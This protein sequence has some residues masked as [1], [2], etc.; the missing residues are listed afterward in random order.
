METSEQTQ[1]NSTNKSIKYVVLGVVVLILIIGIVAYLL[2]APKAASPSGMVSSDCSS[3]LKRE[4]VDITYTKDNKFSPGCVEV[5]AGTKLVYLNQSQSMLQVG[6]DPHP[7]HD[8]NKEL[9]NGEFV[10]EV[11][12][13]GTASSVVHETGTFG[14]HNH[15]NPSATA[16]VVVK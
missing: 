12:E 7:I 4:S 1:T 6:A 15:L 11:A 14:I 9:S 10:L 16:T 13:G 5:T 3:M 8:G 2:V